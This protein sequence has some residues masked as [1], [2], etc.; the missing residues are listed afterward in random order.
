MAFPLAFSLLLLTNASTIT[1]LA[2]DQTPFPPSSLLS[3]LSNS[4]AIS[5]YHTN[6]SLPLPSSDI[7]LDYSYTPDLSLKLLEA[8]KDSVIVG[9]YAAFPAKEL[10]KRLAPEELASTVADYLQALNVTRL[11][12][13]V[14]ASPFYIRFAE[15]IQTY[16]CLTFP[17]V[18]YLSAELAREEMENFIGRVLKP[19]G[20]PVIGLFVDEETG[21]QLPRAL[22]EYQLIKSDYVFF[23][24]D[25]AGWS[26]RAGEIHYVTDSAAVNATN[27]LEYEA[28]VL[29]NRLNSLSLEST[30]RLFPTSLVSLQRGLPALI[31]SSPANL[32]SL[33]FSP[34]LPTIEVSA[35]FTAI[36]YD[37]SRIPYIDITTRGISVAYSEAN[38]R[39]D[40][41]PN[42]Q[43][44]NNSVHFGGSK[45]DEAWAI[46]QILENRKRIGVAFHAFGFSTTVIPL[47]YLFAEMNIS[48]PMTAIAISSSLSDPVAFPMFVRTLSS[49]RVSVVVMINFAKL[50]RWRKVAII[51]SDSIADKD[52]YEQFRGITEKNGIEIT[53]SEPRRCIPQNL[54]EGQQQLNETLLEVLN[55]PTRILI[56][57]HVASH[58]ITERLYDL[59]ARVGD[60]MILI[61][62]GLSNAQFGGSDEVSMKRRSIIRGAMMVIDRHFSGTEGPRVKHLLQEIDGDKYDPVSCVHY[63]NAML[64]AHSVDFMLARGM[65][66]ERGRELMKIMRTTR[67]NGCGGIIQIDP[68]S[69]DRRPGDYSVLNAHINETTGKLELVEAAIYSPSKIQLFTFLPTLQFPDGSTT[70]FPDSWLPDPDCPYLS[71]DIRNF[72]AGKVLG[73]VICFLYFGF[74]VILFLLIWLKTSL[75]G[76]RQLI[77]RV[78][79]SYED[80]LFEVLFLIESL[81][82]L[83][84]SPPLPV[85]IL[86]TRFLHLL[87]FH[88]TAIF[89][90]SHGVF[91]G[92][93]SALFVVVVLYIVL[94]CVRE[95]T[96]NDSSFTTLADIIC[97]VMTGPGLFPVSTTL[98]SVFICDKAVGPSY[99]ASLLLKDC[100]ETCWGGVHLGYALSTF[101]LLVI[102]TSF[103]VWTRLHRPHQFP[104][105]HIKAFPAHTTAH[106]ILQLGLVAGSVAVQPFY[107]LCYCVLY[108]GSVGGAAVWA[109][110]RKGLNYARVDLWYRL[111]LL[112]GMLYGAMGLVSL[113]THN[114]KPL[115]CQIVLLVGTLG[116]A[117]VLLV[118]QTCTK[119]YK[120]L[121]FRIKDDRYDIIKFAF[122]CGKR[123]AQHLQEFQAKRSLSKQSSPSIGRELNQ[124][125]AI[126][127]AQVLIE[128]AEARIPSN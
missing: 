88:L 107:P 79:K 14:S 120:S 28:L 68:G 9:M 26:V 122:T 89:H 108:L 50:F 22:E 10:R 7:I 111:V 24:S 74:A 101:F 56:C 102:Y 80:G 69:N 71:K 116:L 37:G 58:T 67:F 48:V 38:R 23:L 94:G 76:P 112:A 90:F 53:N 82:I 62:Y 91:W 104:D 13:A 64:V 8:A 66:Y 51:Y 11:F 119:T 3:L 5:L 45:Y 85:P 95:Y 87:S 30:T 109:W 16:S 20:V 114:F 106:T 103:V 99:T 27:R 117:V 73:I 25:E 110:M 43:F 31:T 121:L 29:R 115:F 92:I 2:T 44:V 78:R 75:P 35:D 97:P 4:A 42:F 118:A 61:T 100:Y 123:A 93:E 81:Q 105:L 17:Q 36:N 39:L 83:I 59:G 41:L 124:P 86:L 128:D 70:G 52:F 72:P 15:V 40:F 57:A 126:S 21:T 65:H 19:A 12:L 47:N 84:L 1:L 6:Q 63:D 55:S 113:Q 98:L 127:P 49:A 33:S 32:P 125:E 46:A 60:Y 54:T 96:A 18:V 34:R 77:H